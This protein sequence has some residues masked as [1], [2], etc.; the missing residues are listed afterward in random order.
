MYAPHVIKLG[1]HASC[2]TPTGKASLIGLM[3]CRRL[4]SI[5]AGTRLA[6]IAAAALCL[7]ATAPSSA[8]ACTP[9]QPACY[10]PPGRPSTSYSGK[11]YFDGFRQHDPAQPIGGIYARVLNYSP[12]VP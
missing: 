8:S 3:G 1:A 9:G 7:L 2:M 11:S 6:T 10:P 12:W 5:H 4:F